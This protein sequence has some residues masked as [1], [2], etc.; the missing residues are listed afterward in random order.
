MRKK[1]YLK[2]HPNDSEQFGLVFFQGTGGHSLWPGQPETQVVDIPIVDSINPRPK[3]LP[4][5]VPADLAD[6]ISKI[7]GDPIVWW[8]SEFL[9]YILRP[10]PNTQ[11]M[12]KEI[13][14]EQ[15]LEQVAASGSPLVGVHIR[16]TDK[17]GTEAAFH[18]VGE[19]MRHVRVFL[20]LHSFVCFQSFEYTLSPK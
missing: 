10:Q 8:V 17:V 18:G 2:G 16:R 7:H 4:P 6:R 20:W 19:Y 11:A 3:F 13:E 5:A 1:S 14:G 9:R 15:G 12:L